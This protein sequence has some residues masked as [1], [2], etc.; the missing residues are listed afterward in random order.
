MM[1]LIIDILVNSAY[2]F[3]KKSEL[4]TKTN[5]ILEFI[6]DNIK[7]KIL[8]FSI[9]SLKSFVNI[10]KSLI[11]NYKKAL[12]ATFSSN[13]SP[14]GAQAMPNP[15]VLSNNTSGTNIGS[16]GLPRNTIQFNNINEALDSLNNGSQ[17][18]NNHGQLNIPVR[19]LAY[20]IK[21]FLYM[22]TTYLNTYHNSSK[23]NPSG[24]APTNTFSQ[25][26]SYSYIAEKNKKLIDVTLSLSELMFEMRSLTFFKLSFAVSILNT[27]FSI[28]EIIY[29]TGED[30][31][32]KMI[33]F[34]LNIGWPDY[35]NEISKIFSENFN[36]KFK[37]FESEKVRS[38]EKPM[39]R[40]YV[41]MLGDICCLFLV[42]K[43]AF[44]KNLLNVFN[45]IFKGRNMR[46]IIFL[47]MIKW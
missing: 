43:S 19:T 7:E 3:S 34:I 31:M 5:E 20:Y 12:N 45:L 2:H 21:R 33:F 37:K 38:N 11:I 6:D 27:I 16:S 22:I 41:S 40:D 30:P 14:N 18:S 24:T 36:M 1:D 39:K 10:F 15:G 47:D 42:E 13:T 28:R 23:D 25:N 4:L 9:N 35:E 32:I 29:L 46:E 26:S 44:G 8:H 17:N